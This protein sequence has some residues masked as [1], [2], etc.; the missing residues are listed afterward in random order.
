[1][2]LKTLRDNLKFLHWILWLVIA[3]F[4]GMIFFEWG[5][6]NRMDQ[7]RDQAAATVGGEEISYADFERSYRFL[8]Q[9]YRQQFGGNLPVQALD[10]LIN[11]KILLLEARRLGLQATDAEVRQAILGLPVFKDESGGF[12]GEERYKRLLRDNRL[13]VDEFEKSMREDVLR[14][15]LR[16]ILAQTVYV[17]DQE[18]ETA[19]RDQAERAKIRY[20]QLPASQFAEQAQVSTEE[21]DAY[22]QSHLA[23]FERPEQ[24]RIQYLLVDAIVLRRGLEIPE[25][26]LSAYYDDHQDEFQQEEQVRARHI[27]I[28]ITPERPREKALAEIQA[29]RAQLDG[30]ADFATVARERSEDEGSAARG[31]FLNYFSRGAMVK[32][33][34]D[35]AFSAEVGQLVGPV[36]TDYGFHLIEVLDH[37]QSGV[38]PFAEAQGTIRARLAGERSNELAETKARELAQQIK[39][40]GLKTAE[41]WQSLAADGITLEN[42]EPFGRNDAVPGI[43]RGTELVAQAFSAAVGDVSEP[44]KV[45]RGWAIFRLDEVLAPRVPALAEIEASVRQAASVDKQKQLAVGRLTL[46]RQQLVAGKTLD[47]LATELGVEVKESGE[48]GLREQIAGLGRVPEVNAAALALQQ[49]AIGGPIKDNQ[50]AILFEVVERKGFDR[51]A[52]EAAK[53]STRA[54]KENERLNQLLTSLI[55]HRRRDLSP[56]Y[57]AEVLERFKVTPQ[58][59]G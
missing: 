23:D 45:P 25:T 3:V 10:G 43:G 59:A 58:A 14:D 11:E 18:V 29:V 12:I 35:A 2:A 52:Y 13:T 19:Y 47:Q 56:Q 33:F 51:Q 1:M 38:R 27:L 48:F 17:S 32:P 4:V 36:E 30:G 39:E 31:G 20:L 34:E 22:Y 6:V 7:P 53:E 28:Q 50:G 8:E 26:E 15:K 21:L 37:R 54:V 57:S 41:Q 49:G 24:R 42:P 16:N 46:A 40:K 55:E 9:S 44:M 5:G